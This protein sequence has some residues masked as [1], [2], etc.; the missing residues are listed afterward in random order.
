MRFL[1]LGWTFDHDEVVNEDFRSQ[2]SALD[3]DVVFWSPNGVID[4]YTS[5]ST[6][7][8]LPSL[9]EDESAAAVKDTK[10]RRSELSE[11]LR[12][13]RSIVVVTTPSQDCYV[14]SGQ[15]EYSGTGRNRLTTHLVRPH[16]FLTALPVDIATAEAV[17]EKLSFVGE[18]PLDAY[19]RAN[20]DFFYYAAYFESQPGRPW[21]VIDGTDRAVGSLLITDSGGILLFVPS[22]IDNDDPHDPLLLSRE[23]TF[24]E[25]LKDLI[26]TLRAETGEFALPGWADLYRTDKELGARELLGVAQASLA[27]AEALVS[28]S[29]LRLEE[30]S[31]PKLLI[32]ASGRS[33]ELAV[34]EV[35]QL[36]GCDVASDESGRADL[37]LEWDS[38][39][40]VVEVKGVS[41]SAAE[42]HVA[43]L[44][45]WASIHFEATGQQPK[46]LLVV[47]AFR[48][49]PLH[50]RS[51]EVF[52]DQLLDYA[53]A[54]GHCLLSGVQ[55]L[56]IRL[57]V[58]EQPDIAASIMQSLFDCVGTYP[59]FTDWSVFLAREEEEPAVSLEEPMAIP[60]VEAAGEDL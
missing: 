25:S 6:Y 22:L 2:I 49:R 38:K 8:N 48:D 51:D 41:G 57:K 40:A 11:V 15:R 16:D 47:N 23:A 1:S 24:I 44:E 29:Q 9:T 28:Q 17:G 20:R 12:L 58:E 21:V 34:A 4:E 60:E 27:E 19:W 53:N 14:D 37:T 56:G 7:Q 10:R 32:A 13:G 59:D 45:K 33:L 42:Q 50:E 26:N 46:A 54:R 36:L 31:R 43:Q 52:P 39:V 30:S 5:R 18:P 55:M 3:F 35:F